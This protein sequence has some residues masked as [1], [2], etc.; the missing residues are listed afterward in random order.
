MK[1]HF[2]FLLIFSLLAAVGFSQTTTVKK[3][4]KRYGFR[5]D[6]IRGPYLQTATQKGIIVRWRT[7]EPDISL[8]RYGTE[9]GKWDL[10]AG[11]KNL[12][13]EHS[14]TLTGLQ[15]Y[16][17]YYYLIEGL[18]K[19]TLQ[20]DALNSFTT[21]PVA[22]QEH[23]YRIGVFGDCGNNSVNQR[24]TRDQFEKFLGDSVLNAWILLGDNAYSFGK[25]VE[26]QSNFFNIYKDNLL[27]RAPLFPA[28]GNHDYHDERY[29]ADLAQ[30]SK[31]IAYYQNFSMPANGESGGTASGTAAFY[32]YDIGNIHFLSLD[33]HGE[34]DNNSRLFDTLGRQVSWI[35]KDLEANQNKDWVIAYWHHPPFTMGSHNSDEERQLIKIRENF[36]S[37]LERYGVDLVLCGH[38]HSYERSK[39]MNGHFGMETTFDSSRHLLSNSSALYDGSVNSCPYVKDKTNKGTVYVVSGSSGALDHSQ[40][41]FPHNAMYYSDV[42]VGGACLLEVESNRLDLKWICADGSVRDHFTMMKNVNKETRISIRQGE[43]VELKASYIGSYEWQHN[44]QAT[45]SIRVKPGIGQTSYT[46]S[47][48]Y[49]CIKDTFIVTVTK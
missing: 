20:G 10:S 24:N 29:S 46:V 6:I 37:I 8:V 17:K 25:D 48:P 44:K 21:L 45:R 19:D 38:S 34:E 40:K 39:L 36:I 30:T 31:P 41:A 32:S 28:P 4:T 23:K 26:Y 27:K 33:S 9:L 3:R 12:T 7:D 2:L 49:S 15:P 47:D 16:T 18:E 14:V 1:K 42:S 43:T 22:G 5:P 35:K 13:R 11:D